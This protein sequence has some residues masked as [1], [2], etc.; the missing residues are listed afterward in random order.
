MTK[1]SNPE[2]DEKRFK[3]D[4]A[5]WCRTYVH[6]WSDLSGGVYDKEAIENAADEHWQRSPNSDP[7]QIATIEFIKVDGNHS[8]GE[9][10]DNSV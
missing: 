1:E 7:V 9:G 10:N 2:F 6:V 4:R 5:A 8:S 3:E